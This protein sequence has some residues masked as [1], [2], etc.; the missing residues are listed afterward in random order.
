[1]AVAGSIIVVWIYVGMVVALFSVVCAGWMIT[2]YLFACV[3]GRGPDGISVLCLVIVVMCV[4][5]FDVL[6]DFS[7]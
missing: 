3:V 1:M 7:C 5:N 4:G 2:G 6:G